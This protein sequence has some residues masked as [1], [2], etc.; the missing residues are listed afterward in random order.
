MTCVKEEARNKVLERYQ[1]TGVWKC[2]GLSG[3]DSQARAPNSEVIL[4]CGES[5]QLTVNSRAQNSPCGESAELTVSPARRTPVLPPHRLRQCH[6]KCLCRQTMFLSNSGVDKPPAKRARS[7]NSGATL[8]PSPTAAELETVNVEE[9]AAK[10]AALTAQ[11]E[12][13]AAARATKSKKQKRRRALGLRWDWVRSFGSW[14]V[15]F[16]T[17]GAQLCSDPQ[18]PL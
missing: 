15:C 8:A 10:A 3:V 13:A 14:L 16:S 18:W 11:A 12:K 6:A 17:S 2:L 4:L 9:R 1:Y 5:G 7:G